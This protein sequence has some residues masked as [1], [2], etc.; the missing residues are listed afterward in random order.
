MIIAVS[1]LHLGDPVSNR[2]GFLS[3]IE[4]FLEPNSNEITDLVLLGDILDLWRRNSASV[5]LENID[6]LNDVCSLGFTVHYIVGNHDFIMKEISQVRD[7]TRLPEGLAYSPN[8]MTVSDSQLLNNG[9]ESY[10]FIHGH[11]MNYWYTL[12]F[13]EAFSQAMCEV[14]EEVKELS[15]VW[16]TLRKHSVNLSP[17][18]SDKIMKW[19]EQEKAQI[20]SGINCSNGTG[21]VKPGR[22]LLPVIFYMQAI[23][24]PDNCH[25]GHD[26]GKNI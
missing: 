15:N 24:G 12:P 17:F 14:N 3:F 18:T 23:N 6:I 4:E 22:H 5:I 2:A 25:Q 10:H 19:S 16:K 13:Y 8:N 1:D 9:G 7:S 20:I 21:H 11:Q 26:K